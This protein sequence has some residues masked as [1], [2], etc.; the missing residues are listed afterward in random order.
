MYRFFV[1]LIPLSVLLLV[2]SGCG[3]DDGETPI[4]PGPVQ[5]VDSFSGIVT[6]NGAVTHPFSITAVGSMVATLADLRPADPAFP[7]ESAAPVGLALGTW[8]GSICQLVLTH[9]LATT[10]QVVVGNATA[11]GDYC[12]RIYDAAGTLPRSQTYVIVIDHF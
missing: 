11:V 1:R 5:K 9:D 2:M 10:G 8:N 7:P 3:G 6:L 12:V 4:D